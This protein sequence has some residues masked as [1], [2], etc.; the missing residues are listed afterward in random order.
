MGFNI[1]YSM[2]GEPQHPLVPVLLLLKKISF[3]VSDALSDL[4]MAVFP[5]PKPMLLHDQR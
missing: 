2:Q 1:N 4:C 5:V 3:V